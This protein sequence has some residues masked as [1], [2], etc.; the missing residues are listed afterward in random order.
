[1]ATFVAFVTVGLV[2]LAP[3]L[4]HA[5]GDVGGD[6]AFAWSA[7]LTA[8]AFFAVG[9]GKGLVVA[10]TWWRSGLETFVVGGTAASLA[11]AVGAALGGIA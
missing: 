10:R 4:V 9:V 6:N 8:A 3:F 11:Y 1:V 2:P 7:A 5:L